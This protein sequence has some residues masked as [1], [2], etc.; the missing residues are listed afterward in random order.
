MRKHL[1]ILAVPALLTLLAWAVVRPAVVGAADE[2]KPAGGKDKVPADTSNF[3][4][5]NVSWDE[6]EEFC[7]KLSARIGERAR[8]YRLPTEGCDLF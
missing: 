2:P 6:A 3:P 8:K 1:R 4:V 5:E 7:K